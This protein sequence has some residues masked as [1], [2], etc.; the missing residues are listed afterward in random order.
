[1]A[2]DLQLLFAVI[3]AFVIIIYFITKLKLPPFVAIFVG[4]LAA[5]LLCGL[6][7]EL[8]GKSFT[9]NAGKVL[10]DSGFIIALGAMLG[11]I[12]TR[13]GAADEIA[14]F[15][16]SKTSVKWL[17]WTMAGVAMIIGLPL[18]FEVGLVLMIPLIVTVSKRSGVS[19][20]KIAIPALAGM[21]T[22]H[23]LVPPHPGPV[24]AIKQLNADMGLT[25]LIGVLLAIPT[26]ALA[27]PIYGNWLSR[28]KR[29][30][31][32]IQVATST[33]KSEEHGNKP[34]LSVSI[35]L[36]LL[37]AI[38][39]LLRSVSTYILPSDFIA[40]QFFEFI[41]EPIIALTL[42]VLLSLILLGWKSG[43]DHQ[44]LGTT[45]SQSIGPIAVMILTIGAGGG[46]KGV[47][48]AAGI[49]KTIGHVAS[50]AHLPLVLLAWLI[51]VVVRQATG[52]ATVATT[53]TAGIVAASFAGLTG[54]QSS[55]IA[56]AI[57]SGSVF[58]CHVND[59]AYWMIKEYFRFDLIQT[60]WA[61]SVLQ[62]IVSV[63]G[64]V[65]TSAIWFALY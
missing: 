36:I 2:S 41:G 40:A 4:A 10:G 50:E 59:A 64:L 34:S 26:V 33:T 30:Q 46:L 47:L 15:L 56:L 23:A 61:W 62:T 38:L 16:L 51:A 13:T 48:V 45:I 49:S 27:G 25:L 6:P 43:I 60:V 53:T 54:P 14:Q 12:M 31:C 63:M 44:S 8:I 1:M 32:D 39:M 29:F 18:F 17:P 35:L 52:S 57:G 7:A 42:T 65:L 11:S 58:F 20:M 9:E 3:V 24:I 28:H 21:T 19:I 5:G 37:P 55:L 22:L